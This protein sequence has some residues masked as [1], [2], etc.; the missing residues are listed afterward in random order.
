LN[1]PLPPAFGD[2]GKPTSVVDF[3]W[4]H[5]DGP[6]TEKADDLN[7]ER[8]AHLEAV[9]N[10]LA[11]I[12]DSRPR[13]DV[14]LARFAAAAVLLDAHGYSSQR[15]AARKLG[16]SPSSLNR[17]TAKVKRLLRQSATLQKDEKTLSTKARIA[18]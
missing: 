13:K 7:D 16:I 12:L 18:A 10:V 2:D 11:V 17:Q 5:I 4:D 14:A 8:A 1:S 6:Q 3:D 9:Q 15:E